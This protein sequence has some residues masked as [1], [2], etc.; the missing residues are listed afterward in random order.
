MP[1]WK[2]V[3]VS[4]S[5]A[6]LNS[7]NV[8]SALTASGLIYPTTDGDNGDFLTTDGIGN[9]SFGR[10]NVYA[11]V[12]NISGVQLLKGTPVHATGTAGNA[13]EVIAASASVASTMPATFILNE[14]LADDAEG[15]A[16]LTGYINGVNT[17]A[18]GEGD[19]VYVGPTGSFTNIKP[20]GSD[21]LI[22]NLGIITKVNASNG[23][24]YV[25][26][27]GRSNDV[28]NLP[29]GK[30]WVGSDTYTVTSSILTLDEDNSHAQITGSLSVSSVV[31]AGTDTDKFLVLDS[32]NN[33]DFRTG[34]EVR[35]DIGA[36]TGN[37]TVTGTGA[38]NQVT[39]WNGTTSLD[40]SSNFTYDGTTLN[41]SY[42]GTGDLL[43]LTSTDAGAASAPDLTFC[44]DSA[45]PADDDTLGTIQ[46][47]GEVSGTSVCKNYASIY[48]RIA[49]ATN[50]QTKG[51]LSFKAE[52]NNV[53]VDTANFSPN[54]LYVIPPDDFAITSPGIGLTVTGGV[55]GSTTLQIGSGHT[56]S[57]TLSSI[58]GGTLNTIGTSTCSVI[59]GGNSNCIGGT[60]ANTSAIVGGTSNCVLGKCGFIGAGESNTISFQMDNGA[61]AGGDSNLVCAP[62][63]FIGGGVGNEIVR[64]LMSTTGCAAVIGGGGTN[65]T[66]ANHS[67]IGGGCSNCI[68]C[69]GRCSFIGG[70]NSNTSCGAC[71]VIVGGTLNIASSGYGFIGGGCNNSITNINDFM[72][73]GG[74]SNNRMISDDGHSVIV[75]G[76]S[77]LMN[78]AACSFIG[79]GHCNTIC[80]GVNGSVITGGTFNTASG[81]YSFIGGGYQN[82]ITAG[83][84]N[85]ILGG[86][87]N[88]ITHDRSFIIGC[89]L[90]STAASYTFMNNA[91][92][93]G[94]TRT[95]CVIETSARRYKECILPLQNQIENIKKLEPVE[96]QW[97]KDKTKDIGFIAEEIEQ[98]YPDLVAYEEDG[99]ISGVQYSKLTTVLVKALQQQQEQI[100]EL[101]KEIFILKQNK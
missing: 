53:F 18:F 75:G 56:N 94:T 73:I 93:A 48:G 42:T 92:V 87:N 10:P 1:N 41:L 34:A 7:L 27:S 28:P 70:G 61:I 8:T 3:I 57:G 99:E 24:G 14:T 85:G 50:G 69:A 95:N 77:N 74:G 39:T 79:G 40:G 90:S 98:I 21:N 71:N 15:L 65:V 29:E 19:V 86:N 58:G 59:A 80:N 76:D 100:E 13:S 47:Y 46:F 63:G 32:L 44:R 52:C 62:C 83:S 66:N 54:G 91:C 35:S 16:I 97:K 55:S 6:A 64:N 36:G 72:F 84:C 23:S 45:S 101:K 9:L 37:G 26:G 11:N 17:S 78:D 68:S 60:C 51:N 38:N 5:D 25:Y 81:D 96:F 88:L 33:V 82:C 31:N 67:F 49:C 22:Q 43:R 2:K 30:V 89:N 4:G 20:Q 12:K